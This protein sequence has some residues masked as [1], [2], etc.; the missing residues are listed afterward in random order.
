MVEGLNKRTLHKLY[1]KEKKSLREIGK[2]FGFSRTTIQNKCKLY[3][4][5]RRSRRRKYVNLE[6]S[7][8][9]KLYVREGES[10]NEIASRYSCSLS[11]V[12][13]RCKEYGIKIRDA[14]MVK[15]SNKALRSIYMDIEQ[16]ER[17]KE[18]SAQTRV[19]Q[20]VY[21]REGVDLV[22]KKHSEKT[23]KKKS[24]QGVKHNKNKSLRLLKK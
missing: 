9:L 14:E 5:K 2:I 19:P 10:M 12:L 24:K 16:V 7:V 23:R 4:I 17:I 13:K 20:S 1:I 3:G 15:G 11:T 22:L 8:L 18:L 6:K 21:I